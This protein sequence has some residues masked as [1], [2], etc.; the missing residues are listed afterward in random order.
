MAG[1][2]TKEFTESNF[3]TEVLSA[4]EPVLVDFWAEWCMPCKALGPTIDELATEYAGKV[5]VGKVN[6]DKNQS[7]SARYGISSIPTV[8]LFQ[9]GQIK[10]KFVGL[11]S[12]QDLKMSIDQLLSA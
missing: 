1:L 10:Q 5:K 6:T 4:S 3:E 9:D 11:R 8:L 2:N 7:L 12:K